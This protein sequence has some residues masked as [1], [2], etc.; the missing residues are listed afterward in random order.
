M[1]GANDFSEWGPECSGEKRRLVTLVSHYAGDGAQ[2]GFGLRLY[3]SF[4]R[5]VSGVD[6]GSFSGGRRH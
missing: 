6:N 5:L 1:E 2:V 4:S 3:V